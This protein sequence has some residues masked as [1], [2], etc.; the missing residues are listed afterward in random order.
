M[1][2]HILLDLAEWIVTLVGSGCTDE[3]FRVYVP[4]GNAFAD[5]YDQET[6]DVRRRLD[7]RAVIL[8]QIAI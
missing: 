7:R 3:E 8:N 4:E 2:V 5:R 1:S 6:D